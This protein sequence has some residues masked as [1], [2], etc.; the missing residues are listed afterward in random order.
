MEPAS[1]YGIEQPAGGRARGMSAPMRPQHGGSPDGRPNAP[2]G[3]IHGVARELLSQ[4]VLAQLTPSQRAA[5]AAIDLADGGS[6]VN[7]GM[8]FQVVSWRTV[9]RLPGAAPIGG[10]IPVWRGEIA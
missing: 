3:A 10:V 8:N 2:D 7:M 5:V 4:H 6:M 1:A 9:W